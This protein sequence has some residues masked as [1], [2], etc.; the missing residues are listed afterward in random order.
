MNEI[1]NWSIMIL[2]L[3]SYYLIGLKKR[4][5]FILG[6][7]GC[8]AAIVVFYN[9]LP[10]LLMYICFGILNIKNFIQWKK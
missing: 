7:V 9:N 4:Y 2:N 10:L 8:V 5:A 3:V 6:L 1:L